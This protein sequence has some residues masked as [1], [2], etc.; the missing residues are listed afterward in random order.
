MT[1]KA[2]TKL[3]QIAEDLAGFAI[4]DGTIKK[5]ARVY[6]RILD[7]LEDLVKPYEPQKLRDAQARAIR[8]ALDSIGIPWVQVDH[9]WYLDR[10]RDFAT[11]LE[12]GEETVD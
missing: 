2:S 7:T 8:K 3:Q 5:R 4:P 11:R 12:A 9:S 1:S 6:R 10:V